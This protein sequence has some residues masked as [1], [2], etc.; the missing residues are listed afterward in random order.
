MY[1]CPLKPSKLLLPP[2]EDARI[3]NGHPLSQHHQHDG[4]CT[5]NGVEKKFLQ[6]RLMRFGQA[7]ALWP[8]IIIPQWSPLNKCSS[9]VKNSTEFMLVLCVN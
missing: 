5:S 7:L 3:V 2:L 1:D 9:G 6:T 4:V 8:L